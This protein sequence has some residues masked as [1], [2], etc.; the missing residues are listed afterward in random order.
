MITA[1]YCQAVASMITVV[2]LGLVVGDLRPSSGPGP[3]PAPWHS[4][5]GEG[6]ELLRKMAGVFP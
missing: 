6:R 5:S 4:L 3:G 1:R 2:Q